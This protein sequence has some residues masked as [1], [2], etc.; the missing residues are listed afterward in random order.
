MKYYVLQPAV[1]AASSITTS[2]PLELGDI[3]AYSFQ[4]IFS[5]SNVV[6]TFK[7]QGSCDINTPSNWVDIANQTT[8]V[9]A[10]AGTILG[11]SASIYNYVR[12]VWTT[13][14]GTGN[15]TVNALIKETP[16]YA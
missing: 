16:I 10:S 3:R 7:L 14:S 4:A 11:E 9:T 13:T 12:F 6:G 2:A 15:I 5:G 1:S 8:S